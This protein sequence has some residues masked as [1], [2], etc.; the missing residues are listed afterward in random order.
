M[1]N[2][3][4]NIRKKVVLEKRK[5][6]EKM[7]ILQQEKF[8]KDTKYFESLL[9]SI[10]FFFYLS[11]GSFVTLFFVQKNERIKKFLWNRYYDL[12][13]LEPINDSVYD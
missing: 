10:N 12:L 3:L 4:V 5:I 7:V 9:P 1:K 6:E 2:Q 13:D 11:I 8:E